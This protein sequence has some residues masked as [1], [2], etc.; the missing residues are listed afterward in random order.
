M[1]DSRDVPPTSDDDYGY[2]VV[3]LEAKWNA[4]WESAKPFATNGPADMTAALKRL[5]RDTLS[6]LTPHPLTVF[7]HYSHPPMLQ[8]LAAL[9]KLA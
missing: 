5:A 2:D 8:R 3:A 4:Y 6:N 9:R 1:T 7:L